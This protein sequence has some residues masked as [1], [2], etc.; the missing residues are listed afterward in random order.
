M[1]LSFILLP[2]SLKFTLNVFFFQD[3][4]CIWSNDGSVAPELSRVKLEW[5]S[6]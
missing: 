5:V 3:Y 1:L 2:Y 4:S 6:F